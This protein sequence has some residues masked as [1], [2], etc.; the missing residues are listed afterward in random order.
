MLRRRVRKS[1]L[2]WTVAILV[3][4]L[5]P[6]LYAQETD[7]W[8]RPVQIERSSS[9]DFIHYRVELTFDLD[10]K[11][12]RGE[13]RITLAPLGEGV[14]RCEIDAEETLRHRPRHRL[15]P[16][17]ATW[18]NHRCHGQVPRRKPPRRFLLRRCKRR[19]PTDGLHRLVAE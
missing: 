8:S 7:I 19:P 18:C 12:F 5:A 10:A 6:P 4:L 1:D 13:N 17:A 2:S 14:D 15:P 3:G 16:P 11:V 9:C